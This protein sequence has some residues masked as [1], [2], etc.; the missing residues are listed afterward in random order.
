MQNLVSGKK[1]SE[2]SIES[3]KYRFE[4]KKDSHLDLLRGI[5]KNLDSNRTPAFKACKNSLK[6]DVNRGF[7]CQSWFSLFYDIQI[8]RNV[9]NDPNFASAV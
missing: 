3:K 8:M 9:S 6:H 2:K 4:K 7:D 1:D 5:E